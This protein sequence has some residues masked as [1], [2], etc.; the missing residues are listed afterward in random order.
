MHGRG[1][2]IRQMDASNPT[3]RVESTLFLAHN[4]TLSMEHYVT[5]LYLFPVCLS[6]IVTKRADSPIFIIP[7]GQNPIASLD[8]N[9]ELIKDLVVEVSTTSQIHHKPTPVLLHNIL[10]VKVQTRH[11]FPPR[12][13]LL[14]IHICSWFLSFQIDHPTKRTHLLICLPHKPAS[15]R[16][17][18][19][20]TIRGWKSS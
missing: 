20:F 18:S 12:V 17:V 1:Q 6:V 16:C 10:W 2:P 14:F 3:M 5:I 13:L 15:Y 8:G 7:S 11:L 9:I 4:G 19:K